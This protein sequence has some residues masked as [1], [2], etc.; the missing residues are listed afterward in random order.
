MSAIYFKRKGR[1]DWT[2]FSSCLYPTF[3]FSEH[4]WEIRACAKHWQ[5]LFFSPCNSP[6]SAFFPFSHHV[7]LSVL[8]CKSKG[9]PILKPYHIFLPLH[10]GFVL[11]I[12]MFYFSLFLLFFLFPMCAHLS[13]L[14]S[15]CMWNCFP[16]NMYMPSLASLGERCC[17]LRP[18]WAVLVCI[19]WSAK[20]K[21]IGS[22]PFFSFFVLDWMHCANWSAH[23][24]L[25]MS[26][27]HHVWCHTHCLS[28][29]F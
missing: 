17:F 23:C 3:L 8:A 28:P 11:A 7:T 27:T 16:L 22:K 13:S 24:S 21:V 20:V 9:T 1:Y 14:L 2:Y 5:I 15:T 12:G 18:V 26:A 29:L 6:P 25:C 4:F 19:V 10:L